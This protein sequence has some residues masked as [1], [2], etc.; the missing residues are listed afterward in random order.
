MHIHRVAHYTQY[1]SITLSTSVDLSVPIILSN[2]SLL[3]QSLLRAEARKQ[4]KIIHKEQALSPSVQDDY[5][6]E[7]EIIVKIEESEKAEGEDASHL[8][9]FVL[10]LWVTHIS[11]T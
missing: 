8:G 3:E 6:T 4:N 11:N 10:C 9:P 2:Y 7:P 5:E 1:S